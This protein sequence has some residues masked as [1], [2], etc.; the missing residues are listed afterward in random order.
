MSER[1][2]DVPNIV[3]F[4]YPGVRHFFDVPTRHLPDRAVA[5][6]DRRTGI[7]RTDPSRFRPEGVTGTAWSRRD[8]LPAAR[9]Y[10]PR[11]EGRLTAA[12]PGLSGACSLVPSQM[13][14]PRS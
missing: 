2:V 14:P 13:I 7:Q 4:R 6:Q 10:R 3:P 8:V 11:P 5:E 1:F 9:I 12:Y